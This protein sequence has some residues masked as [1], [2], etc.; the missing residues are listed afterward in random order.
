MKKALFTGSGVAITTPFTDDDKIDFDS[1]GKHIEFLIQNDTDAIIVCG[2]TGEAST[3]TEEEHITTVKY[4]VEKVAGRIPVIAGSGS[5]NTAKSIKLSKA[6]EKAGADGL[7][8]VTPYYNKTNAKGLI[9]HFTAIHDSVSIPIILYNVPSRTNMNI[10]PSLCKQ[11]NELQGVV[12]IKEA[13]ADISQ[14]SRIAKEVPGLPI[15][16][17]ND[18]QITA[19]CAVGGVGVITVVGNVAP[20]KTHDIVVSFLNGDATRSLELQHA[21]LD[22]IDNLFIETNPIPVKTALSEMGY[23]NGNLRLPLYAMEQANKDI[24]L[25]SL[26]QCNIL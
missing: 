8:V 19:T 14:I 22:L 16:T 9:Q 3:M 21:L 15:Y 20:K 6:C 18:D 24:L 17:G 2:T 10:T 12:G 25:N 1:F 23:G 7:L 26:K 11:L 13:S 5:N 4:C